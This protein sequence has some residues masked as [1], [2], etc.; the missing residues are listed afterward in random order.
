VPLSPVFREALAVEGPRPEGL[1][2]SVEEFP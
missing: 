2:P 1:P